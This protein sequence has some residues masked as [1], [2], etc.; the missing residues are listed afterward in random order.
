MFTQRLNR[1]ANTSLVVNQSRFCIARWLAHWPWPRSQVARAAGTSRRVHHRC[2]NTHKK[3]GTRSHFFKVFGPHAPSHPHHPLHPP[4]HITS[5]HDTGRHGAVKTALVAACARVHPWYANTCE[6]AIGDRGV[7]REG[8]GSSPHLHHLRQRP[9]FFCEGLISPEFGSPPRCGP[10][11]KVHFLAPVA[12]WITRLPTEQKIPSSNLGRCMPNFF[13]SFLWSPLW[14]AFSFGS[15]FA[16]F[17]HCY[18]TSLLLFLLLAYFRDKGQRKR[19]R[20][21]PPSF[22]F[23]FFLDGKVGT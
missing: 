1:R 2:R 4:G 9:P 7:W 3:H 10:S 20:L 23:F 21:P 11:L 13:S 8:R 19:G 22:F 14:V 16:F 6:C 17:S 18:R 15:T 5:L 12:Q